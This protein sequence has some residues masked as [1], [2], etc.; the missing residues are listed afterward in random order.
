MSIE[1]ILE[2]AA[3]DQFDPV[4]VLA[5]S[6]RY[7]I[8]RAMRAIRKACL[9]PDPTGFNEDL[10]HGKG[11]Q[12]QSVLSACRTLPMMATNRFVLVRDLHA[13]NKTEQDALAEYVGD[14]TP[15]TCLVM[16]ADKLDGRSK[17]TKAAKKAGVVTDAKPLKGGALRAFVRAE[18][19]DRGHRVSEAAGAALVDCLGEDLSALSDAIERLSLF[20]G[21]EQ[22]IEIEA[23]EACVTRLRT[24]SIWMLVDAVSASNLPKTMK[25]AGSLLA[26]REPPLRILGMV[27][28][29]LRMV[30]RMRQALASGLR[31]ADAAKE[32]GAPPFKAGDLTA[33][34]RRF[35]AAELSRAFSILASADQSLKG[36]KRQ[37]ELILEEALIRL[38][39]AP[40]AS[41]R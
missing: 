2:R 10:F 3:A 36:S 39:S 21:S 27:A 18:A 11:L 9:G 25:A 23:V 40:R 26:D 13:M 41:A 1:R 34:A 19:Q 22:S 20:V 15:S 28:R 29:Q 14:P 17:L 32:A 7:L 30:A 16:I 4:T 31:G 6:E 35:R 5:G 37:P 12:A 24:E 8:D 33:S 38:C